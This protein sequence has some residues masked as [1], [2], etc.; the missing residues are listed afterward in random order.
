MNQQAV[1]PFQKAERKKSWLKFA[2]TGP[3][4]SGKTMSALR[5]MRGIVGTEGKIALIDTE[6]D[7]ASLYAHVTNFDH[8][9]IDPPYTTEK[10]EAAIK[11][12]LAFKYDALIIDSITHAWAGEGGLLDQKEAIDSRGGK[13]DQNKYTNWST[14]TKKHENFKAWIMKADVHMACTM[15]SKQDYVLGQGNK[16]I[17]VGMAPIQRDGMEYEFTTVFDIAMNHTAMATK[18]RTTLFDQKIFIITE[19]IGQEIMKWHEGGTATIRGA[20]FQ[21][22]DQ[23]S[24]TGQ[25]VDGAAK[26]WTPSKPQLNRLHAIANANNYTPEKASELLKSKYKIMSS[27]DLNRA[28][29]DDL[30]SHMEKFP[31]KK[32]MKQE[33]TIDPI[34]QDLTT[35]VTSEEPAW[36]DSETNWDDSDTL[37]APMDVMQ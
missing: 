27:A 16:P 2:I 10:Y 33:P 31:L 15:R 4:G 25:I 29:Y 3:S 12:A 6:H 34:V 7:S 5:L 17:K 23:S 19:E 30:C 35:P 22:P 14:I 8:L 20:S 13:G 1:N 36:D 11:A 26:K 21:A 18:D 37:G 28:Q 32:E 24:Q 9:N